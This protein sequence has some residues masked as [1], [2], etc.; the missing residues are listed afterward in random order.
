MILGDTQ[1]VQQARPAR[2]GR[3]VMIAFEDVHFSQGPLKVLDGVSF[4]VRRGETTVILGPS[5]CGK[6]TVLWLMLGVWKPDSGRIRIEGEDTAHFTEA[7]WKRVRGRLSMVFQENALFDS[8]TVGE[9][10]GYRLFRERTLPPAEIEHKVRETLQ[11][12]ELDPDQFIDRRPDELST[13]QKRRVA[14][15]RAIANSDP[16]AIFYDEPTTGLDPRTARKV[17]DLIIRLRD[18][19]GNTSVV[20]THEIADALRLGDRF[21]LLDGGKVVYDGGA[22]GLLSSTHPQVQAFLEPFL[23]DVEE[24]APRITESHR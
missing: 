12:V 18:L 1:S 3:D 2:A 5:G 14:I 21:L 16:E 4:E 23:M 9:N 17:G 10:V 24:L 22:A 20:V 19:R 13:G 15:A 6:S 7:D 8:L 11:I